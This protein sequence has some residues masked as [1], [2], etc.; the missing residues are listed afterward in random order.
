MLLEVQ[1]LKKYF[2][3][4]G[5][6]GS[7]TLAMVKAVDGVS[8][9]VGEGKT[10]G[11]VGESGCGKTTLAR[12]ILR[13]I[14]PNGGSILLD[15]DGGHG[16]N[17]EKI[18]IAKA[19]SKEMGKVRKNMQMVFQ[20][21][22]SSLDPRMKIKRSVAEPLELL[23]LVRDRKLQE[24]KVLEVL[25]EVGL[26][27]EHL[28]RYPHEFSGGQ[29]QRIGVA[30]A[31][32]SDPK[33]IILDEPT[34]AVDVSVQAQIINL[35]KR[36][37]RERRMGYIFIT[38]DLSVVYQMADEIAVMYLGK[39]VECGDAEEVFKTPMHPYTR[40]LFSAIPIP[41]VKGRESRP[42]IVLGGRVPSPIDPPPGCRFVERCYERHDKMCS[43]KTPE[44]VKVKPNHYVACFKRGSTWE[45]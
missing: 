30:R 18:D 26:K 37:Q 45:E 2:P 4:R 24:R 41:E 17:G 31:I 21:P 8:F 35:L 13:L 14:E 36:I 6:L 9:S 40:A 23:S 20:D 28:E 1:D 33:L 25:E 11:I 29:K 27:P 7:R 12:T 39:I 10:I 32:I 34:S 38:H 42:R 15:V 3:I 16:K 44:L 19:S 5:G 43:E 22:Q